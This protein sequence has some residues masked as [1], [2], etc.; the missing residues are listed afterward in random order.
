M[1]FPWV[2]ISQG[3]LAVSY[4]CDHPMSSSCS[5]LSELTVIDRLLSFCWW[6]PILEILGFPTW[7]LNPG[8][9][10]SR[11]AFIPLDHSE[12]NIIDWFIPRCCSITR[13]VLLLFVKDGN[14]HYWFVNSIFRYWFSSYFWNTSLGILL[15][16][17]LWSFNLGNIELHRLD[18]FQKFY[19]RSV[20]F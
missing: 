14:C 2:C 17:E 5:G 10:R 11:P 19:L 12:A 7:G 9:Q 6:K 20:K 13:S 1:S 8:L 15:L 16:Y 4:S 18:H 3:E